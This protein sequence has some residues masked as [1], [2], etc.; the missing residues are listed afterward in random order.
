MSLAA[1]WNEFKREAGPKVAI[2]DPE[3]G[4][5]NPTPESL[6]PCP[7]P[8]CAFCLL[9]SFLGAGRLRKGGT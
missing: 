7:A 3:S 8:L 5:R 9:P 1:L 6:K 2:R 4:F